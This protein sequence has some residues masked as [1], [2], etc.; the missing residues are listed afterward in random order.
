MRGWYEIRSTAHNA[1]ELFVYDEI[2][3]AGMN[4]ETFVRQVQALKGVKEIILR[5]NSP[6]GNG[7]DGLAAFNV[8]AAHPARIV[9]YID[10][11][12][13]SAASLIAM[14]ADKI[15]MPEN[16]AMVIHNPWAV[17]IGPANLMRRMAGD[18]DVA[19]DAYANTY[20]KR[21]G[22]PLDAVRQVMDEDRLMGAPEC[23]EKGYCDEMPPALHEMVA[24]FSFDKVPERH[25]A[26]VA[27]RF[28][29]LSGLPGYSPTVVMGIRRLQEQIKAEGGFGFG[30]RRGS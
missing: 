9:C 1:V 5:I 22:Q 29:S 8:L 30:P 18:L 13:A 14:A 23:K 10:G 7:F 26:A 16:T 12:A 2:G 27:A 28:S 25:R 19:S 17:A 24:T 3:C 6:G 15:I 4:V 11:Y 21:S 20:A